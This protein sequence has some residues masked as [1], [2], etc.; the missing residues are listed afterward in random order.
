MSEKAPQISGQ[1]TEKQA[2]F[3]RYIELVSKIDDYLQ[4]EKNKADLETFGDF[5]N[6]EDG[7]I[8]WEGNEEN[9]H[10]VCDAAEVDFEELKRLAYEI[11]VPDKDKKS[12]DKRIKARKLPNFKKQAEELVGSVHVDE[13]S[14]DSINSAIGVIEMYM[15]EH[16]DNPELQTLGK[17]RIDELKKLRGNPEIIEVPK[18]V[19]QVNG[20]K[21]KTS[22]AKVEKP[23]V[24]IKEPTTANIVVDSKNSTEKK[25]EGDLDIGPM[26]YGYLDDILEAKTKEEAIEIANEMKEAAGKEDHNKRNAHIMRAHVYPVF[27]ALNGKGTVDYIKQESI[28]EHVSKLL[29]SGREVEEIV[30]K[31]IKVDERPKRK[32]IEKEKK[33]TPMSENENKVWRENIK[34]FDDLVKVLVLENASENYINEVKR[35]YESGKKTE[36]E[37]I[38]DKKD[39][40]VLE[41]FIL[42]KRELKDKNILRVEEVDKYKNLV[43]SA[44]SVEELVNILQGEEFLQLDN[45]GVIN[46]VNVLSKITDHIEGMSGLG[47]I[48]SDFGIRKS[49]EKLLRSGNL[50][51]ISKISSLQDLHLENDN[52]SLLIKD[53]EILAKGNGEPQ[54]VDPSSSEK[55]Q[56]EGMDKLPSPDDTS[57]QAEQDR[58]K[59]ANSRV[60]NLSEETKMWQV[61]Q[62]EARIQLE[63]ARNLYKEEQRKLK[64]ST[65][66]RGFFGIFKTIR[67][68]I[69]YLVPSLKKT[70]KEWESARQEYLTA[71]KRYE[72]SI[73]NL[74]WASEQ[75]ANGPIQAPQFSQ[76]FNPKKKKL[77]LEDTEFNPRD[78]YLTMMG[79]I[80]NELLQKVALIEYKDLKEADIED[81]PEQQKGLIRKYSEWSSKNS[82]GKRIL[83][84]TAIST[85]VGAGIGLGAGLLGFNIAL[86]GTGYLA[87]RAIRVALGGAGSAV[88][89]NLYSSTI[90]KWADKRIKS[91]AE[92]SKSKLQT[93][94]NPLTGSVSALEDIDERERR[95][96]MWNVVGKGLATVAGGLSASTVLGNTLLGPSVG[97]FSTPRS[98]ITPIPKIPS[99]GIVDLPKPVSTVASVASSEALDPSFRPELNNEVAPVAKIPKFITT[100]NLNLKDIPDAK[101]VIAPEVNSIDNSSLNDIRFSTKL[102][103]EEIYNR[104][105][106]G[107]SDVES[108][109]TYINNELD[110][111][112]ITEPISEISEPRVN[113]PR[114][115]DDA[116]ITEPISD[117]DKAD[118][119][120][121]DAYIKSE[122]DKEMYPVSD[123]TLPKPKSLR[124]EDK[125]EDLYKGKRLVRGDSAELSLKHSLKA[126]AEDLGWKKELGISKEKWAVNQIEDYIKKNPNEG[127]M[128]RNAVTH[129]G[130]RV[131]VE[132]NPDGTWKAHVE[133][134]GGRKIILDPSQNEIPN[135]PNKVSVKDSLEDVPKKKAFSDTGVNKRT[136]I[137]THR[138]LPIES[139][140]SSSSQIMD[141]SLSKPRVSITQDSF[142]TKVVSTYEG[143][144]KTLFKGGYSNPKFEAI[145]NRSAKEFLAQR[146]NVPSYVRT[147]GGGFTNKD[148]ISIRSIF[149]EGQKLKIKILPK[150][151][152]G[153]YLMEVTKRKLAGSYSIK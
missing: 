95:L 69:G 62:E 51:N 57:W 18:K 109:D 114:E 49:V 13:S 111:A 72:N 65:K 27:N 137:E 5:V 42:E 10:I 92:L 110:D 144:I 81:V 78:R 88:L 32:K 21:A 136:S 89:N 52:P 22:I 148:Y 48:T 74:I 14:V 46:V 60:L 39:R 53:K 1:L 76:D 26:I 36:I 23:K 41:K 118:L 106:F 112:G 31:E 116:G 38:T 139:N 45:R 75:D 102:P 71:R 50:G 105:R 29:A 120:S 117:L 131:V 146:T 135:R 73:S 34:T 66:P 67:N 37:K 138:S 151:S 84:N 130:D 127:G 12:G 20:H 86:A 40:D 16:G 17:K 83:V 115:L 70:N 54:I 56:N 55:L 98:S 123:D 121:D 124:F 94:Y 28:K 134:K 128:I 113:I 143:Q 100:D 25:Q 122:I 119:R 125:I 9:I 149:D 24:S 153:D 140:S 126:H 3:K 108:S 104:L 44:Q 141:S 61:E 85:A 35:V 101:S 4:D 6:G 63:T 77:K 96:K 91:T 11:T 19:K 64:E 150:M 87:T 107:G 142:N 147:V 33:S 129:D 8:K 133:P 99:E 68:T 97:A 93:E 132:T 7:S 152:V 30:P 79:R 59:L 103:K 90:G 58:L 43:K 15:T 82:P 47:E 2:K 145:V 80:S